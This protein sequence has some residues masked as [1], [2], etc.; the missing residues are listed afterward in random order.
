MID[1]VFCCALITCGMIAAS[2]DWSDF[3]RRVFAFEPVVQIIKN[4]KEDSDTYVENKFNPW[5]IVAIFIVL[6]IVFFFVIYWPAK[7]LF[8]HMEC[9]YFTHHFF[10]DYY[11]HIYRKI[12]SNHCSIW[13]QKNHI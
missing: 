2:V 8:N 7:S 4:E 10:D 1:F 6:I 3:S 9:K 12:Y 11:L 5:I 13:P